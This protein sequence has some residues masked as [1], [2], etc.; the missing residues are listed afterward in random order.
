MYPSIDEIVGYTYQTVPD[1]KIDC[2]GTDGFYNK[3]G[4]HYE[5][6]L[7]IEFIYYDKKQQ[8][9]NERTVASHL[10]WDYYPGQFYG[11]EYI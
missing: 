7:S 5:L 8:E 2:K 6:F 9:Y 1:I 10:L 4:E 11:E 3:I